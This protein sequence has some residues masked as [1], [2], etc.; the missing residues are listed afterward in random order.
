MMA[1]AQYLDSKT[2]KKKLSDVQRS[3]RRTPLAIMALE[4]LRAPLKHPGQHSN[5]VS[6]RRNF[7]FCLRG[8]AALPPL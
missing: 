6:Q 5:I 8:A 4:R 7:R 1:G 2:G 3:E